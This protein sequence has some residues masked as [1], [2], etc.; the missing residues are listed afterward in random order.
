MDEL[1]FVYGMLQ[2]SS[3]HE[4]IFG[5]TLTGNEEVLEK[6]RISRIDIGGRRYAA[7]VPS[8]KGCIKCVVFQITEDD[9][10]KADKYE[11][12]AYKRKKLVLKS[13]KS[14]WAYIKA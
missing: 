8:D 14:A 10:R 6:Y 12:R 13:G 4:H 3:V 1:L 5:R 9:L 11:G 2:E 7:A